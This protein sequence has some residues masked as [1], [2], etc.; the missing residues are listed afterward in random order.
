M[1]KYKI[2]LLVSRY[3]FLKDVFYKLKKMHSFGLITKTSFI[4]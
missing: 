3:K 2:Q 4:K 1:M